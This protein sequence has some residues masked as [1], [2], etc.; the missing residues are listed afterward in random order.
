M[1]LISILMPLKNAEPYLEECLNSIQNQSYRNWELL[2]VNDHSSDESFE[3]AKK[4]SQKDQ[5]IRVF[6][7]NESGIIPALRK[8]FSK[9][10]GQYIHRMDADDK[11]PENKLSKLLEI[12]HKNGKGTIATGKVKYFSINAVSDGYLKYQNWLNS[13]CE[14]NSH[15]LDIYKECVIASPCW[16]IHHEDLIACEAFEPDIY[17]EDYDLVFRFYQYGLKVK[18][19]REVLHFWRDHPERTSRNDDRYQSV[20]FFRLKLHYFFLMDR[21]KKRPLVI[22][23]AGT[24]GKQ[25]AKLLQ[26]REEDFL[27][28]SNNPKKHGK[29]IYEEVLASFRRIATFNNPQ[30]IITVA[31]RNAKGEIIRFLEGLNLKESEDYYFFR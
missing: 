2:I 11:M 19:S 9:A 10:K 7:Q 23:G 26:E 22:W 14:K 20:S 25:M 8:A 4:Y 18:S 16:L 21:D 6:N 24:K 5:R 27:W 15:W 31:Q 17:P 29:E 1:D 12:C 3:I 30:I 28:V 13:L